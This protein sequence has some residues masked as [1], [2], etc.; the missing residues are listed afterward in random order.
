MFRKNFRLKVSKI[1][2]KRYFNAAISVKN[3]EFSFASISLS[4]TNNFFLCLL[5]NKFYYTT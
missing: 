3:E 1:K 5:Y 2:D 4:R